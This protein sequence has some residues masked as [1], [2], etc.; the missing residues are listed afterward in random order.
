[1]ELC[2]PQT[3]Q[4]NTL[5]FRNYATSTGHRGGGSSYPEEQVSLHVSILPRRS[6]SPRDQVR[7]NLGG[8]WEGGCRGDSKAQ[9]IG[10]RLI[11]EQIILGGPALIRRDL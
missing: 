11:K 6:H 1:M 8:Y 5:V 2:Q 9:L 10:I 7:H 3:V 4:N